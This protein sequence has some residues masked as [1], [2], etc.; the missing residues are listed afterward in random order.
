[1]DWDKFLLQKA[2][3]DLSAFK[4]FDN[5][6][7]TKKHCII[8][9]K[10]GKLKLKC[11]EGYD[12]FGIFQPREQFIQNM[13]NKIDLTE[14]QDCIIPVNMYDS[15]DWDG[16]FSFLWAK[17]YNKKGLLFPYLLF[18]KWDSIQKDFSNYIP[19]S[20]RSNEPYFKGSDNLTL[21]KRSNIRRILR[22]MYPQNII[23]DNPLREP[24]TQLMKYKL[25]FDIPGA[26]PWS[27]R[28]AFIALSG[29]S[30]IRIIQYNPGWQEKTWIQF[31]EEPEDIKGIVLAQSY[32]KPLTK[33][34]LE[35]LNES[36]EV[37]KIELIKSPYEKKAFK[38]RE[39]LMSLKTEHI[40]KYISTICNY[41]GKKQGII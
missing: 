29:S 8:H 1:M 11:P 34:H 41:I 9:I 13:F 21:K 6:K 22:D 30:S 17:P 15:Y 24:E 14:I 35:Y 7:E 36:V 37:C 40:L 27:V 3:D 10:E 33:E 19:W 16:G 26:K 28:S 31:Y 4:D 23:L 2:K 25:V 20:E 38:E 12:M 32:N 5:I 39:K 18:D